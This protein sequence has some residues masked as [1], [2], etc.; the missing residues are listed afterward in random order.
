MVKN[1]VISEILRTAAVG[2]NN[3][4]VATKTTGEKL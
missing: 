1:C 4:V 2:G 3:P